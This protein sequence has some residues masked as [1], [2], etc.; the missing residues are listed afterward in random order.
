MGNKVFCEVPWNTVVLNGNGTIRVCCYSG[1]L[2][3]RHD[4]TIDEIWNCET[5]QRMRQSLLKGEFP[6][7]CRDICQ[8]KHW[9]EERRKE[10]IELLEKNYREAVENSSGACRA[11]IIANRQEMLSGKTVLS[12]SPYHW[13]IS[14]DSSCNIRC[15]FC[16][17]KGQFH[18]FVSDTTVLDLKNYLQYIFGVGFSGGEPTCNQDFWDM[19]EPE[20]FEKYPHWRVHVGTNGLFMPKSLAKRMALYFDNVI[21]SIRAGEKETYERQ[22]IGGSWQKLWRNVHTLR[23]AISEH[24]GKC[25]ITFLYVIMRSNYKEL[26]QFF[27]ITSDHNVHTVMLA[28]VQQAGNI[29]NEL[30]FDNG[31]ATELYELKTILISCK[32]TFSDRITIQNYEWI[33]SMIEQRLTLVSVSSQLSE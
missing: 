19:T 3:V 8:K 16:F 22:Q 23:Q 26:P 32:E 28:P 5:L 14:F 10:E 4:F 20:N 7:E 15:T 1:N 30:I 31:T 13:R 18:R 21:I 29:D 11:N 24:D 6:A 12:T 33:Q 17:N 25:R 9:S 2:N 27:Q